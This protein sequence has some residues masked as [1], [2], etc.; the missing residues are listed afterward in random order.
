MLWLCDQISI[1]R[2]TEQMMNCG[3]CLEGVGFDQILCHKAIG[4]MTF[5]YIWYL[6]DR[7]PLGGGGGGGGYMSIIILSPIDFVILFEQVNAHKS[8]WWRWVVK[9]CYHRWLVVVGPSA[10]S[11]QMNHNGYFVSRQAYQ[12]SS[13]CY[14]GIIVSRF[15]VVLY[16]K[17]NK[18]KSYA[19]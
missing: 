7:V 17:Q 12:W 6:E 15:Y 3:K 10:A 4:L 18:I 9:N 16:W 2:W 14:C 13:V 19:K 11:L 5:V 8:T 1:H